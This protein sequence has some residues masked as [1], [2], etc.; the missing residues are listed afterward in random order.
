MVCPACGNK[1]SVY[2][3]LHRCSVCGRDLESP[4]GQAGREATCPAC[5]HALL[6]PHDVLRTEA[7]DPPDEAWFGIDC[8]NCPGELVARKEDAGAWVVCP[9]CLVPLTV[10]NWG[11][12]LERKRPAKAHDLQEALHQSGETLC[13]HCQNHIPIRSATCPFCGR[14]NS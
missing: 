10:P 14:H 3:V 8:P 4:S 2:A 1:T 7:P 9:H 13:P 11:H 5:T 12:P 6:V